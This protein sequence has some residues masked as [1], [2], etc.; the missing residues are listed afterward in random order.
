MKIQPTARGYEATV[1]LPVVQ[2]VPTDPPIDDGSG[3]AVARWDAVGKQVV[4]W[5]VASSTW[6]TA[7]G[8]GSLPTIATNTFLGNTSGAPAT[9][10]AQDAA[11]LRTALNVQDSSAVAI[12][13]GSIT[14]TTLAL[15]PGQLSDGLL[16]VTGASGVL[17]NPTFTG[18]TLAAAVLQ[19]D[20][21]TGKAGGQTW[22]GGTAASN[23]LTIT[24][25]G[26]ATKGNITLGDGTAATLV[27]NEVGGTTAITTVGASPKLIVTSPANTDMRLLL[28]STGGGSQQSTN[29]QVH[30]GTADFFSQMSS[31]TFTTIPG[32]LIQTLSGASG[33]WY[34]QIH[35]AAG[36]Y[37]WQTGTSDV[38]MLKLTSAGVLTMGATATLQLAAGTLAANGAVVVTLTS[39]GPVGSHTTVQEWMKVQ[40]TGGVDR[41]IPMY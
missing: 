1:T 7:G 15:A 25:T 37:V 22:K 13:G 36:D 10:S 26:N 32:R 24:S 4:I 28:N 23:S 12:T 38:T 41:W 5:D 35:Q 14:G 31:N 19:N 27:F 39:V 3:E 17:T 16:F 9:A 21:L 29:I 33:D 6:K 8:G 40:G 20:V 11:H 2:G 30:A 34:H 18:L